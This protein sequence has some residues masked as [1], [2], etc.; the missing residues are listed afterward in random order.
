MCHARRSVDRSERLG[1]ARRS[2]TPGHLRPPRVLSGLPKPPASPRSTH[3]ERAPWGLA[4]AGLGWVSAQFFAIFAISLILA[5]GDWNLRT[6]ARPGG[7]IGRAVARLESASPL[8]DD[9]IP[10][11]WEQS[12]LLGLWLGFI[13]VPWV[14][15]TVL[16]HSRPGWRLDVE[17]SDVSRGIGA[18]LLLQLVLLPA[19]FVVL[20]L[21]LGELETPGRALSITD[22]VDGPLEIAVLF[23]FVAVGAP[24]VEE[25]FYRGLVQ[26]ALVR[27][28]GPV[29]GIGLAG[30]I[31][32]A[33][34]FS[35]L[36]LAPLTVV[37]IVFGVVAWRSGRVAPAIIG[38]MTF[39][40]M[41]LTSLFLAR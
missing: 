39:N 2:G 26:R 23:L 17:W 18:G 34:H 21:V 6:P 40:A 1:D 3:S 14:A 7:H 35:L 11:L 38:H 12:T 33:V 16:N 5:F 30:L 4:E 31:F 32:G 15:A 24:I 27:M 25:L 8:I 28:L 9:S 29:L 20:Q 41:T 19:T 36:E 37:G 10:L 22:R 13:G